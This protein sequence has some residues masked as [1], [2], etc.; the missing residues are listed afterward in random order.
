MAQ[1]LQM[2]QLIQCLPDQTVNSLYPPASFPIEV[3][4]FLAD[5]IESQRWY[6]N[7][8]TWNNNKQL[9]RHDC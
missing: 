7:T 6:T 9:H 1:W 5:W 8:C 4:H 3:R 2:S